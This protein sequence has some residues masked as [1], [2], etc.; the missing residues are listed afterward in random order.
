MRIVSIDVVRRLATFAASRHPT[1]TWIG[2]VGLKGIDLSSTL[3]T[4]QEVCRVLKIM[5]AP[6][7][8]L[9]LFFLSIIVHFIRFVP[10]N[11]VNNDLFVDGYFAHF[12]HEGWLYDFIS[13]CRAFIID[14]L[15]YLIYFSGPLRDR[16]DHFDGLF[17]NIDLAQGRLTILLFQKGQLLARWRTL[18]FGLMEHLM[19]FGRRH[20]NSLESICVLQ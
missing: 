8:R 4:V 16:W 11:V 6:G 9:S 1:L 13:I 17:L 3:M 2:V 19:E 15:W 5:L 20:W 18:T 10:V 12:S 14:L 7:W